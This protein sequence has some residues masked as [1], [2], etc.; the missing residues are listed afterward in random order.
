[1]KGRLSTDDNDVFEDEGLPFVIS[2]FLLPATI[3]PVSLRLARQSYRQVL[4]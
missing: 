1:M 4:V 3:P 2:S